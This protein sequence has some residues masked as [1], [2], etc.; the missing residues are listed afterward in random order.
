MRACEA[1]LPLSEREYRCECCGLVLDRDVNAARNL[2]VLV[3]SSTDGVA[4][5]GLETRKTLVDGD[6]RPWLVGPSPMK[7]EAGTQPLGL[8]QTGTADW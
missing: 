7:R 8:D 1:K 2:A 3:D 6:S 4:R 5:S